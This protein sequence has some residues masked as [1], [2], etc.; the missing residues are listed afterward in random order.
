ME[1]LLDKGAN[2]DDKDN[3]GSTAL[4]KAAFQ[5]HKEI[6]ELLLD[7]GAN[8]N[9]KDNYGSTALKKKFIR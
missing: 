4:T 1:L 5:G 7:K 9:E 3:N 8:I 2:I 6:V